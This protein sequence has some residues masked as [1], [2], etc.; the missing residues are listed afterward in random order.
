MVT[1]A[2]ANHVF[3]VLAL[4]TVF[5]RQFTTLLKVRENSVVH[6]NKLNKKMNEV[7]LVSHPG[8]N[9]K[10]LTETALEIVKT[11]K[12]SYVIFE[13]NGLKIFAKKDST[14]ESINEE[15]HMKFALSLPQSDVKT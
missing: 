2:Y 3:T 8:D 14:P 11:T 15:Y 13:I 7:I 9:L 6:E 10:K 1:E 4:K 12:V 5:R